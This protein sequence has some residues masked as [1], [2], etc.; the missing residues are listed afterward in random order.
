MTAIHNKS[1]DV[2]SSLCDKKYDANSKNKESD[3]TL[4]RCP[5]DY[6]SSTIKIQHLSE[7]IGYSLFTN[8]HFEPND[9]L[10]EV[11]VPFSELRQSPDMHTIQV[12]KDWH[13]CTK[14]HP[15]QYTQH[16]CFNINCKF[17]L[18][19][20]KGVFSNPAKGISN[21]TDSKNAEDAEFAKFK[22][23]ALQPIKPETVVTVNYNSF[24]WEMSCCFEDSEAPS[25]YLNG[26]DSTEMNG[27]A[28]SNQHVLKYWMDVK[29]RK[30]RG[31]KFAKP[32]EQNFLNKQGLLF[33][34]IEDAIRTE[35]ER[36]PNNYTSPTIKIEHLSE[37]I[38]YS[39]FT[40]ADFKPNDV[41]YEVVIPFSE[42]RRRPDMHTIQVAKERHWCT[43]NHP[44]QYT[45]HS[46]F[47]IN[48]KFVLEDLN[49]TKNIGVNDASNINGC[50][51]NRGNMDFVKFKLIALQ[52]L[53][54]ETVVTVNYNS[55]EWEMSCSF[56]DAEAPSEYFDSSHE[57]KEVN[58]GTSVVKTSKNNAVKKGREVMGYKFA[59][60]DERKFLQDR[61]LLFRHIIDAIVADEKIEC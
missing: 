56:I 47:N 21:G 13:W 43:K 31:Y 8:A 45:Q 36:C 34:H 29:G 49:K 53:E 40:N 22:L 55:F 5:N 57:K 11:M 51:N 59:K 18:E 24:E 37:E 48:C 20:N 14:K 58:I 15:I 39:L 27:K 3:S 26:E 23:I 61:N 9:V 60:P 46:C 42:L 54:P 16:S 28:T 33:K 35:K 4:N 30:V 6:V 52:N 38:G 2:Y 32:D 7:D 19:E 12:S 44:I 41:L 50:F 1:T 25:E 10:F 17:V